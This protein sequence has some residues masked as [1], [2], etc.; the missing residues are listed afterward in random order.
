MKLLAMRFGEDDDHIQILLGQTGIQ[1]AD[2]ALALLARMYPHLEP[3]LK[4]RLFLE[5][6]LRTDAG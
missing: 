5:E 4:T 3:P 6:I 2:E 1:T